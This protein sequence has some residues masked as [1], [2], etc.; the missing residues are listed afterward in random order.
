M[1]RRRVLFP[2]FR[3]ACITDQHL[4]VGNRNAPVTGLFSRS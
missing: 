1:F 3:F 4:G 2:A